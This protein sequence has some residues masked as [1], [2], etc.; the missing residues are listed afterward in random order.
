MVVGCEG[1]VPPMEDE[2]YR[3]AEVPEDVTALDDT[4]GVVVETC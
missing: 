3:F 2:G 4:E 1:P